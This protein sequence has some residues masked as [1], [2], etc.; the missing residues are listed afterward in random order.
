MMEIDMT[1]TLQQ[2]ADRIAHLRAQH[3]IYDRE[4]SLT[5]FGAPFWQAL[6]ELRDQ[7]WIQLGAALEVHRIISRRATATFETAPIRFEDDPLAD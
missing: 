4:M 6:W 7:V 3:D 5:Q 1:M 2:S